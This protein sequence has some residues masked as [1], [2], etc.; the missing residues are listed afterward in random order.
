MK[1]IDET[2]FVDSGVLRRN[3]HPGEIG[4]KQYVAEGFTPERARLAAQA[5]AMAR[6][7]HEMLGSGGY[8]MADYLPKLQ[9][10]LCDAGVTS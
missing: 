7:M 3:S 4:K 2:W 6:L 5:P 10:I 8:R 1:P 9:A